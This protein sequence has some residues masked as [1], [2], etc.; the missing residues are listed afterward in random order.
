MTTTPGSPACYMVMLASSG[1]SLC[2]F[3]DDSTREHANVFPNWTHLIAP[4]LAT[5]LTMCDPDNTGTTLHL[6]H[7]FIR[8]HQPQREQTFMKASQLWPWTGCLAHMDAHVFFL[9][10]LVSDRLATGMQPHSQPHL[11]WLLEFSATTMSTPVAAT[12]RRHHY[13]HLHLHLPTRVDAPL[14]ITI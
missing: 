13:L 3:L 1:T 11:H 4:K 6:V 7:I 5:M 9:L 10:E 14:S 12:V 8:P 2:S